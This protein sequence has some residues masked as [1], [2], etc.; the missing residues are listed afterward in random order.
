[1]K[2]NK[3]EIDMCNGSI[4]DKLISFALPLM[5]SGILQ[6]MFNAVDLVVVGHFSGQEALAAVG[7]T[8]ALIAVFTNL[9]IGISLGA[10]VLAARFYAAGREKEMSETVHTSI[11]LA[12]ISGVAMAIVG[13]IFAK[14][15]L[16][17]MDTPDNV[18]DLSTLYMRIYFMGMPFF[19]L[20]NY[21]AAI[22]RAVGDTKRP[23]LFLIVSGVS[24]A[25][26]NMIL[27]IVF[28]LG[29]AGVA[30]GTV[31]SQLMSCVLVLRCLCKTQSSYQ[32]HLDRLAIKGDYVKLIFQVGI[33]AGIQ[34]TVIN[35][36]NVLL[37]SSVNSFGATAMAGYTAA[38][39]LLG[40]LYVSVNAVTQ[41]CMSFTSQNYGVRKPKRMDRVLVDCMILSFAVSFAMGCGAYFFG[42]QLLK[43]YTEDP[44]VIQ[45]G[46]EIL[47]Y[48]TV[49]YFLCGQMDLFPGALRGM[50]RSGVPMILSIIGTVGLRIV[51][52]FG[53]FP[54]HRSLK[55]LFISYPA[56]WILTIIMQVT[57][58]WF[59]RRKVHRQLLGETAE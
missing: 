32:L 26:L 16:Q 11:M 41:A 13:V 34:S 45:C 27:V 42:P 39:N 31:M 49:T 33:P 3:Y 1:M 5:L 52:I 8:T 51:W 19:M 14:G 43:I 35:F 58:F 12:L 48:T 10:N 9:F 7:S 57:C 24:N 50:G 59:V 22:L 40:F 55:V 17:L 25:I 36:S 56:S 37:Q 30:I 44:K 23:L 15:A 4:M 18:I 28:N 38:N 47:A 6:L 54:A 21:G 46:M 2:K 29:V 20:Y 53:I